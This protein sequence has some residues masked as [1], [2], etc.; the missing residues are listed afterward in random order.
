LFC[1]RPTPFSFFSVFFVRRKWLITAPIF[2]LHCAHLFLYIPTVS[3]ISVH[4]YVGMVVSLHFKLLYAAYHT[5]CSAPIFFI[6]S[7]CFSSFFTF[8]LSVS[9]PVHFHP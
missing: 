3:G 7:A 6:L 1:C 5:N 2:F 9:F 4:L 8:F